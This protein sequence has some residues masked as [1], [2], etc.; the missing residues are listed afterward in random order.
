MPVRIAVSSVPAWEIMLAAAIT[1]RRHLRPGPPG[2]RDLLRRAAAHRRPAAPA[3]H[4]GRRPRGLSCGSR[5]NSQLIPAD[6]GPRPRQRRSPGACRSLRLR[7]ATRLPPRGSGRRRT[8]SKQPEPPTSSRRGRRRALAP[9]GLTCDVHPPPRGFCGSRQS[10][11][12]PLDTAEHLAFHQEPREIDRRSEGEQRQLS[13]EAEPD[14]ADQPGG[15]GIDDLQNPRPA[16][17]A[18]DRLDDDRCVAVGDDHRPARDPAQRNHV[19]HG[20][21]LV[22]RRISSLLGAPV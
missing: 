4:S 14:T 22:L 13:P 21:V 6:H 15:G 12:A 8:R 9:Q 7:T 3:R 19:A 20:E 11:R 10:F 2:W 16:H 18:R 1:A 17:R 5:R